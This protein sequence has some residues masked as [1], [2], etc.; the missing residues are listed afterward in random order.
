MRAVVADGPGAMA[1]ALALARARDR[2]PSLWAG[3]AA[4][5]PLTPNGL[6]M[7]KRLGAGE[8][9]GRVAARHCRLSCRSPAGCPPGTG[10]I[11]SWL[12]SAA[13][14]PAS[15]RRASRRPFKGTTDPRGLRR[16]PAEPAPALRQAT[17]HHLL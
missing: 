5:V 4:D 10:L 7:L 8:G 9:I 16:R 6:Q 11:S 14:I 13:S 3:A 15:R 12:S 17:A 1:A 2:R